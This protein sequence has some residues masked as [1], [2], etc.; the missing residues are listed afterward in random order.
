[1]TSIHSVEELAREFSISPEQVQSTLE[2]LDAGLR[3]PFIGR[4]H[5]AATGGLPERVVRIVA[6]RRDELAE[7]DRRPGTILRSLEGDGSHPLALIHIRRRRR[8]YG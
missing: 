1:M 8:P 2:M 7:L 3:A 6:Q 5:G 4:V